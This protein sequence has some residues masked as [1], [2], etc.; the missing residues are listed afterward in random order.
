MCVANFLSDVCYVS[1]ALKRQMLRTLSFL[2][3]S[4]HVFNCHFRVYDSTM[5]VPGKYIHYIACI[6]LW[7]CS[8]V[9]AAVNEFVC[10]LSC[11]DF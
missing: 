3:N 7:V 8:L 9:I 1:R 4:L 10:V 5:Q 6:R 11:F 2:F